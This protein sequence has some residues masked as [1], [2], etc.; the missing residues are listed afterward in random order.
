M[1]SHGNAVGVVLEHADRQR[2]DAAGDQEAVHGRQ[3]RARRTLDEVDFLSV[4]RTRQDNG[5]AGRVAVAVEILR[6]RMH[7]DVRAQLDGPLQVRT[8]E[9]VVDHQG[10]VAIG[11]QLGR[12]RRCR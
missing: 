10:D 1:P 8:Q 3:A 2:L 7:D 5:A 12:L 4:F 9:G 6:H 11:D